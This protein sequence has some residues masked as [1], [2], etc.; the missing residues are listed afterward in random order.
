MLD[1][2]IVQRGGGGGGGGGRRISL[3]KRFG[4]QTR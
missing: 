3:M 4:M 1:L 2:C